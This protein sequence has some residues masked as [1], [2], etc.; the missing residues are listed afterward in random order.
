M[1]NVGMSLVY[2]SPKYEDYCNNSVYKPYAGEPTP[3]DIL[4][5]ERC[6]KEY[7]NAI[8]SHNQ[9]RFYIFA[10][11]GFLL[12]IAGLF[13]FE[14]ISK[15]VGLSAG[16]ILTIQ[17]IVMNFQNK[18]AVFVSLSAILLIFGVL[19]IKLVKKMK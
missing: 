3:A 12:M 15:I 18:L 13:I 16:G 4:E 19:A 5:Q 10:G 7:N 17:G 14:V 11:I 9:I 8:E 6:S 2:D 1:V